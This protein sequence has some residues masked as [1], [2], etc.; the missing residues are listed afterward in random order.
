MKKCGIYGWHNKANNKWYIGQSSNTSTR[1]RYHLYVLRLGRHYNKHLQA[2]FLKYGEMSFD[3]YV[4]EEVN[5]SLLNEK[6]RLWINHYKSYDYKFGY[7]L[8]NGG[9]A[10]RIVS[11]ETKQKQSKAKL[12]IKNYNY[13]KNRSD[14]T[15]NR[16]SKALLGRKLSDEHQEN[17]I[18]A[19]KSRS[20]VISEETRKKLSDAT[21]R[22]WEERK[23]N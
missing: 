2:A 5:E 4:L 1:R 18:K 17:L 8:D 22:I 20:R 14:I 19:W 23:R 7:N 9:K 21:K 11:L 3:F 6:E 15:C 13:G 10:N 16:I 12:G